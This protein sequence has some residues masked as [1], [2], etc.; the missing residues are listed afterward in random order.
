MIVKN[1]NQLLDSVESLRLDW[2][3]NNH[4]NLWYRGQP[5]SSWNVIPG[6]FRNIK[7]ENAYFLPIKI[8]EIEIET[9]NRFIQFGSF[10]LKGEKPTERLDWYFLAQHY[11]LKT[12]SRAYACLPI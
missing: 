8:M 12:S 5:N 10:Y 1:I 9:L 2:G 7:Q 4:S 3:L 11:G 6:S